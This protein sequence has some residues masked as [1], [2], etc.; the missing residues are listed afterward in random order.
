MTYRLRVC[1][2]VAACLFATASICATCAAPPPKLGS[3]SLAVRAKA[4]GKSLTPEGIAAQGTAYTATVPDTLDLAEH[5]ELAVN[6]LIGNLALDKSCGVYQ[7]F[8]F[9]D[10]PEI[11]GL[12]WNLPAKNARA[13]PW[14]RTI[15]GS[16]Q[17]LEE[18]CQLMR[19]LLDNV[20]DD[21]RV[22]VPIDNDG[23]PKGTAYPYA[24]GLVVLAAMNWH[25]RDNNPEWL[26]VANC[27]ADA[28]GAVAIRAE[29]RAYFP[30]ESSL[31]PTGDWRWTLRGKATIP[32]TPPDE[33]YLEQ[34]GLEGCV[35][36]EQAAPLRALVAQYGHA[37]S[38]EREELL[39]RF[40]RFMTKP[41][42]WEDTSE[43]N[44]AGNEH[45]IFAGHFHGNVT[46]LHALLELAIAT[47]DEQ[48][49]Q[50]V[51][52]G[53]EHARR[54]GIAR[55]GWSPGWYR[56]EKYQRDTNLFL[57]SETCGVADMLL[58]ATKLTDAGLG[59]YWDDVDAIAR[60]HLVAQQIT[61]LDE[62][63][64]LSGNKPEHEEALNRFVGG[65]NQSMEGWINSTGPHMWGCCTANGA[66]G[67]YYAWHGITRFDGETATVNMFLNRAAPWMDIDSYLP[68]E[69]KLVLHNKQ[70]KSA[71][72]RLPFW[73]DTKR[74]KIDVDG[75]AIETKLRG[76]HAI[77]DGLKPDSTVTLTFP[78]ETTEEEYN[79]AGRKYT[80]KIKGSTVVDVTPRAEGANLYQYYVRN[81]EMAS[82]APTKEV[83]R[84]AADKILPLQ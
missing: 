35:K 72:V 39:K 19:S 59:D 67:L 5:A 73:I 45:G 69:G 10:P 78:V 27:I 40:K 81:K 68:Y 61:D 84:F 17:G 6:V 1:T 9:A 53:Y 32:Y 22:Y 65:F 63:R 8:K 79:V 58:L 54:M 56:P 38:E 83:T 21:G 60:N 15:C 47:D 26:V 48:L 44:Y 7:V 71:E 4:L 80:L 74:L 41:G 66:I 77:I 52:E 34:Q 3:D 50:L 23:A 13:L 11:A 76:R 43:D 64:R 82:K 36:Y 20:N 75:T 57:A 31:E 28:I 42:L 37:P 51:R 62:M 16:K 12:T 49:K 33:P 30:P 70:A 46:S 55:M 24:N 18:E 2:A 14:M 29:N 25:E